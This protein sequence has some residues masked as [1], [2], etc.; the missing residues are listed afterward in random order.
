MKAGVGVCRA[1]TTSWLCPPMEIEIVNSTPPPL[2]I[3]SST[4]HTSIQHLCHSSDRFDF[5]Q[6]RHRAALSPQN[7]PGLPWCSVLSSTPDVC[8]VP[9]PSSVLQILRH[10]L[11]YSIPVI[12]FPRLI[13][14]QD[15]HEQREQGQ[16][17]QWQFCA[18]SIRHRG[19]KPRHKRYVE[20]IDALADL[21]AAKEVI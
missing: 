12:P 17:Q 20:T 14:F 8:A 19:C 4:F 6:I 3:T 15:E 1:C 2:H 13:Y 5:R 7:F 18:R 10:R 16:F 9:A 21:S 11:H